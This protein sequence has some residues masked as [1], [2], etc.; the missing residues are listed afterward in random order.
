MHPCEGI[1]I[2]FAE[3]PMQKSAYSM[4]RS[5]ASTQRLGLPVVRFRLQRNMPKVFLGFK[6]S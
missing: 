1:A 4:V 2:N 6:K 3:W 5:K